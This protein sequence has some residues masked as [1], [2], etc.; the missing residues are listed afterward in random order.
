MGVS[1]VKRRCSFQNGTYNFKTMCALKLLYVDFL[2]ELYP[3]MNIKVLDIVGIS[4][5]F[6]CIQ[7]PHGHRKRVSRKG[8]L[9]GCQVAS[10]R[11]GAHLAALAG[12]GGRTLGP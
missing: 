12:G 9:H 11:R 6:K 5:P 1:I 2:L 10:R 8:L 7:F 4:S 3:F